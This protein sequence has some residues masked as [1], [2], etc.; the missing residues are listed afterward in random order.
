MRRLIITLGALLMLAACDSTG[1]LG[2]ECQGGAA[3]NDCVEGTQCTL[4]R[5]ATAAPPT[6]PNV[7]ERFYCRTICDIEANCPDG[8]ECRTAA[9]TMVRTCQPRD[10]GS[11]ADAGM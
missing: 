7:G 11:T 8:F 2:D 6:D 3:T 9:G 10:D 4:A 1:S 5:S